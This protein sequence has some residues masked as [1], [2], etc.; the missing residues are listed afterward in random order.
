MWVKPTSSSEMKRL[1]IFFKGSSTCGGG[2][3]LKLL[4]ESL[5]L[6]S[7]HWEEYAER[8]VSFAWCVWNVFNE[9]LIFAPNR[10]QEMFHFWKLRS[11][12]TTLVTGIQNALFYLTGGE[13]HLQFS[14]IIKAANK[15]V[16]SFHGL[17]LCTQSVFS[18]QTE[19]DIPKSWT[20]LTRWFHENHLKTFS[21]WKKILQHWTSNV[22]KWDINVRKFIQSLRSHLIII[23]IFVHL[24]IISVCA[25]VNVRQIL[26]W[27]MCT[28]KFYFH[29]PDVFHVCICFW[30]EYTRLLI[31][32]EHDIMN[33]RVSTE[34]TDTRTKTCSFMMSNRQRRERGAAAGSPFLCWF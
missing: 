4:Q 21:L 23:I 32:E 18:C 22:Y 30:P 19:T 31:L 28:N 12:K 34:Q 6:K 33:W 13:K 17:A 25:H 27:C 3:S 14:E 1:S 20:P 24:F 9:L 15:S 26:P 16:V 10:L 2:L 8:N 11:T 5:R 29:P 7:K